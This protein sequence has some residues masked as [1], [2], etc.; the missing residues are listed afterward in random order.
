[1]KIHFSIPWSTD[2]NI[3]RAYNE[4][5]QMIPSD[6]DFACFI[7]GDAMFLHPFFGKQLEEIIRN[8]PH[9]G[10]FTATTNRIGQ[11]WQRA[12]DWDSNDI[13]QHRI[14]NEQIMSQ[15]YSVCTHIPSSA[16]RRLMSGVLILIKKSA[17]KKVGGFKNGLL[18]VDNEL[19]ISAEKAGEKIML[20]KGV[21]LYHWYRGG[22]VTNKKHLE[23]VEEPATPESERTKILRRRTE[24]IE[25]RK[26]VAL[27]EPMFPKV[28]PTYKPS[29][30]IIYSAIT[31]EYDKAIIHN[32]P[33]GW[34]YR[35]YTNI[36]DIP[37]T[38]YVESDL[39]NVK[40]AR[41]IKIM[42]WDYF[43]FDVCVWIDGNTSFDATKIEQ[44][45]KH[46]FVIS[47]HPICECLYDEGARI[48]SRKKDTVESINGILDRYRKEN[49]PHN[50]GMVA[51]HAIIR[52]NNE[53]NKNFCQEWWNEVEKYSHRDQM[54][55]NYVLW[56]N[57]IPVFY[58]K[59]KS[60][61][62]TISLHK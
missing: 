55:F 46:D 56:K 47:K 58:I 36:K 31:G 32:I 50:L 15:Y 22:D 3:G 10:I 52:K 34:E 38:F 18:G 62:W 28:M 48:L 27:A 35:L 49:V 8:Y 39:S 51:S 33:E 13:A 21:Y 45:C 5:M 19:H 23:I 1:M 12:G 16:S 43:D 29:R 26:Q 4:F 11:S 60:I 41:R 30:K 17:W 40:L 44:L 37:G 14:I 24:E 54:S 25:K 59:F 9:C 2:K 6:D 61:F 7:D 53:V 42:P 20:M 57:P